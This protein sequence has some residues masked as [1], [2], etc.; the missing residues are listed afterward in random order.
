MLHGNVALFGVV[1]SLVAFASDRLS[2]A[3]LSCLHLR[4]HDG[5]GDMTHND[6]YGT[7]CA[8]RL[9][10]QHPAYRLARLLVIR[11]ALQA[12]YEG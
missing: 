2:D 11:A 7:R 10:L 1:A 6:L 3:A 8:G 5:C 12:L 9:S 4:D